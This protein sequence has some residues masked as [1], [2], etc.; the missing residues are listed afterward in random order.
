[1]Q[2]TITTRACLKLALI[3]VALILACD[4]IVSVVKSADALIAMAVV[5]FGCMVGAFALFP[6]CHI[7]HRCGI[8]WPLVTRIRQWSIQSGL[9][10][11][12]LN[13]VILPLYAATFC[14][15]KL[16]FLK[17]RIESA[18]TSA[19]E[20]QAFWLALHWG[21]PHEITFERMPQNASAVSIE[22]TESWI[23]F[24]H[25]TAH[26]TLIDPANLRVLNAKKDDD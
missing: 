22:W 1:M 16:H 18:K 23:S 24:Q 20:K 21:S 2:R 26:R 14:P 11:I 9:C 15:L 4:V 3:S 7:L 25:V 19:E 12:Y 10:F 8:E 6:V 13:L 17:H 5:S